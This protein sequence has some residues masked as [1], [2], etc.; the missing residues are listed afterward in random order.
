MKYIVRIKAVSECMGIRRA[1]LC[2]VKEDNNTFDI[3]KLSHPLKK[4]KSIEIKDSNIIVDGKKEAL[5]IGKEVYF[6]KYNKVETGVSMETE[7]I[8]LGAML[9]PLDKEM[10]EYYIKKIKEGITFDQWKGEFE[11]LIGLMYELDLNDLEK[12]NS[13]YLKAIEKEFPYCLLTNE[14]E[15]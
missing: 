2:Y 3:S 10:E 14:I 6:Y 1:A 8:V 4:F 13:W 5:S 7:Q 15:S 9:M 11:Y 12:A